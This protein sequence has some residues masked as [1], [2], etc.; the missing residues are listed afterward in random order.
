M[1]D[2]WRRG[3]LKRERATL[4][5]P[6]NGAVPA[7]YRPANMDGPLQASSPL[8]AGG[9]FTPMR[10]GKG[11]VWARQHKPKRQLAQSKLRESISIIKT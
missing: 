7:G 3:A 6:S 5:R 2:R 11:S 4:S 8:Q 9:P 10:P 1:M